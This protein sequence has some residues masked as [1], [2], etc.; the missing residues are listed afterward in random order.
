M[1]DRDALDRALLEAADRAFQLRG[2][3]QTAIEND[4]PAQVKAFTIEA[5]EVC[6]RLIALLAYARP[7]GGEEPRA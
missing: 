4:D 7:T 2:L 3:L 5:G 1:R 6:A